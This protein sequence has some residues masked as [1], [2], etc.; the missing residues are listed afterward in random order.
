M[1]YEVITYDKNHPNYKQHKEVYGDPKEFGYKDLVPL[2]TA[3]KFNA[4][5]WADLF[6]ESGARFAGPCGEHADGF[7]MWNSKINSW[8]AVDMGPKRDIVAEL[9]KAIRKR[10]LKY[11]VSLHHSWLWGW[12]PTW[13]ENTDC[14]DPA[15]VSLYGEKVPETAWRTTDTNRN[16]FV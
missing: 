8:N 5:E 2:F 3:P 16:N 1:L 7:A 15:N 10:G 9:E 11:M 14:A 13:D 12:F 6:V 4:D